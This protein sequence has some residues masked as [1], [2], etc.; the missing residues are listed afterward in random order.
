MEILIEEWMKKLTGM[1]IE[2]F[3]QAL[4]FVGLQG[5]YRRGEATQSSDIDAVV[6]LEQL[7]LSELKRYRMLIRS[8]QSAEKACGFICGK[9]ELQS[10][11]KY[12]LFQLCHD[13]QAFYG[14]LD[15][16]V[17]EIERVDIA[18]AVRINAANLYHMACHSFLFDEDKGK[19]LKDLY[20]GAFY[21]LQASCFL[22]TGEYGSTKAELLGMLEG[23]DREILETGIY[24]EELE[25]NIDHLYQKLLQWCGNYIK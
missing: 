7:G 10:W 22:K 14:T 6:I 18:D 21:L 23:V 12:D 25:A 9:G 8:M 13:T 19:C 17:P 4:L 24:W 2:E 11:P 16:L 15:S 1:L 20:K 3:G 5:S